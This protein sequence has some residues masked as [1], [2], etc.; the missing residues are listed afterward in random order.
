MASL[1]AV[2]PLCN[3][4]ITQ[5]MDMSIEFLGPI[6]LRTINEL[7]CV[8]RGNFKLSGGGES[9]WYFDAKKLIM[10][11]NISF[12]LGKEI[13]TIANTVN[14]D[15]VGGPAI[16]AIPLVSATITYSSLYSFRKD[17]QDGKGI[18]GFWVRPEEK[19]HGTEQQIEGC[20]EAGQRVLL[21]DDVLTTGRAVRESA[22]VVQ[23]MGCEVVKIVVLLNR[24]DA[25]FM[26]KLQ[27]IWNIEY[28]L[29][30]DSKGAIIPNY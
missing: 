2:G 30:A 7:G 9:G 5:D 28:M 23:N 19:T 14:A 6:L 15:V 8:K 18:P 21:V 25:C 20:L 27:S 3:A 13:A 17:R 29:Q 4:K 26:K 22:L 11:P 10:Q 16:S 24:A 12:L 1:L